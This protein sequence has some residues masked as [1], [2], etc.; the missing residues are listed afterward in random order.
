MLWIIKVSP[1]SQSG[2][3]T[4]I[5]TEDMHVSLSVFTFGPRLPDTHAVILTP[6][7]SLLWVIPVAL[8]GSRICYKVIHCLGKPIAHL[9]SNFLY[10]FHGILFILH[11]FFFFF[12]QNR[13]A[14]DKNEN[15]TALDAL[16]FNKS[17]FF[18]VIHTL[19]KQ[20]NFSVK[21]RYQPVPAFVFWKS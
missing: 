1:S 13:D 11:S 21:D 3:F 10:Y 14:S 15:F 2:G 9:L 5:F 19:E 6:S 7:P 12:F 17:F 18:T 20:K 16:I 4:H 8:G